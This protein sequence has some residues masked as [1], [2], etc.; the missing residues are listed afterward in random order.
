MLKDIFNKIL[1]SYL[2]LNKKIFICFKY[3]LNKLIL[4]NFF[5]HPD[6]INYSTLKRYARL[7]FKENNCY[8]LK[9]YNFLN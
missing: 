5:Q 6:Y 8:I 4:R 1:Y 2:C 3:Y 7:S 9:I